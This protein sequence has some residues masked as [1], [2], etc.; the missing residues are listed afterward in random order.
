MNVMSPGA[1][2]ATGEIRIDID[3]SKLGIVKLK[4]LL[5]IAL[6]LSLSS[7]VIISGPAYYYTPYLVLLSWVLCFPVAL[8]TLVLLCKVW[9]GRSAALYERDGRLIFVTRLYG[10]VNI[11]D[12]VQVGVSKQRNWGRDLDYIRIE[13]RSGR[14]RLYPGFM[15]SGGAGAAAERIEARTR[16]V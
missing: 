3:D 6:L 10:V 4:I 1:N 5:L 14:R 12:V 13:L 11:R 2:K 15:L 9:A 16:E 8:R 7:S